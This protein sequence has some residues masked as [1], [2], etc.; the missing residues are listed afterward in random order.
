VE[1]IFCKIIE[2]EKA[3]FLFYFN[4]AIFAYEEFLKGYATREE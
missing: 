1:N 3:G 2:T 4:Y